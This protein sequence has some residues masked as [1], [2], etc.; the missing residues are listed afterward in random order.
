LGGHEWALWKGPSVLRQYIVR[1]VE[2]ESKVRVQ[3]Y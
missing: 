3:K 1:I 2:R